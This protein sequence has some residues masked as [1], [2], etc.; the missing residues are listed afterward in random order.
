M[1]ERDLM[2][3]S[4]KSLQPDEQQFLK[5]YDSNIYEKVSVAADLLVFTIENE[6][7]KI[8]MIR[9]AEYPYKGY[10]ALP[11]VFVKPD[12]S[13]DQAALRGIREE[14]GLEGIYFEQM[15]T[16]GDVKRD[17][18]SRVISVSYLALVPRE[19][20][21]FHAGVRTSETVLVPVADLISENI[22]TAFDHKAMI[23]Y[24]K[25]RLKNKVEYT[26]IAFHFVPELFTLPQLQRVY[27]ILLDKPLFKAN[28]R[29][30]VSPMIEK[31]DLFTSGDAHR[32]SQYY[33]RKQVVTEEVFLQQ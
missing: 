23:E 17:P 32:P 1:M 29:K 3:A 18:R 7:L 13:V 31:T 15:Y 5:E 2:N 14:T 4:E 28:F 11:G 19:E 27:E 10:L 8:L 9:R 24:G 21:A 12:E 20:L 22:K 26:D 25:W 33:R 16:F 6:E 30:K